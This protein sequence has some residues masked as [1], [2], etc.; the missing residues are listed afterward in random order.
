MNVIL[1]PAGKVRFETIAERK[2][3]KEEQMRVL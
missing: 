3:K 2:K 1:L